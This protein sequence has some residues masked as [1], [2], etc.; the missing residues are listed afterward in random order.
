MHAVV[1]TH[2]EG[3]VADRCAQA[4]LVLSTAFR[5]RDGG[6]ESARLLD[7]VE[8]GR[9]VHFLRAGCGIERG[10]EFVVTG[11]ASGLKDMLPAAGGAVGQAGNVDAQTPFA[12]WRNR[13]DAD[14][15]GVAGAALLC[16]CRIDIAPDSFLEHGTRL[17]PFNRHG[18]AQLPV[19]IQRVAL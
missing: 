18:V 13:E 6:A 4:Y 7:P 15:I 8:R 16:E 14:L 1:K 10:D 2:A 11:A 5:H 3:C 17:D 19:D 9:I 12:A